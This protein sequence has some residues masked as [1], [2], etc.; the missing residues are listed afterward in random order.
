MHIENSIITLYSYY[1]FVY[2]QTKRDLSDLGSIS[3]KLS[4][5]SIGDSVFH[6]LILFLIRFI[7]DP[8][9]SLSVKN[10]YF[11]FFLSHAM[12]SHFAIKCGNFFR[13]FISAFVSFLTIKYTIKHS[14][15]IPLSTGLF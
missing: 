7:Q 12:L 9:I 3:F 1:F 6:Y 11:F 8:K 2:S 10:T 13:R 15:V 5:I 4:T 14:G